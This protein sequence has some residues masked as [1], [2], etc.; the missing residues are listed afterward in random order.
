MHMEIR[1]KVRNIILWIVQVLL[2]TTFIWSA[3]MKLFVPSDQLAA[4][5]PW[6][7]T[8]EALTKF[9][10]IVDFTIAIGLVL[11]ML[12]RIKPVLTLYAAYATIVLMIAASAFHISRGEGSSIGV[13]LVFLLL[14]VLIAWG[15]R[16]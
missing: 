4:M 5:W 2:A 9:T 3:Y 15:R 11:P 12:L 14:A 7:A 13:N 10:G 8:N 16:K 1:S 6:T